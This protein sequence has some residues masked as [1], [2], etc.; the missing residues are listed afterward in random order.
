VVPCRLVSVRRAA[1]A[2]ATCISLIH[3]LS[4]TFCT[5]RAIIRTHRRSHATSGI[6][7][8]RQ[9]DLVILRQPNFRQ[10]ARRNGISSLARLV[11]HVR[12]SSPIH[13]LPCLSHSARILLKLASKSLPTCTASIIHARSLDARSIHT[14][15]SQHLTPQHASLGQQ[16][17]Q[18]PVNDTQQ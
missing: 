11:P 8:N 6:I 15:L 4:H 2:C 18:A 5:L 12:L 13:P 9:L 10:T 14:I 7:L 17:S 16:E 1:C 3:R